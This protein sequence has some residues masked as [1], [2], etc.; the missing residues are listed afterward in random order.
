MG[1]TSISVDSVPSKA[2]TPQDHL[3]ELLRICLEKD[4]SPF[5]SEDCE[6]P[7]LVTWLVKERS[8]FSK[9]AN[10][11]IIVENELKAKLWSKYLQ[12]LTLFNPR[13]L[14]N[15]EEIKLDSYEKLLISTPEGLKSD[16]IRK[17]PLCLL[18]IDNGHQLLLNET[19]RYFSNSSNLPKGRII[20]LAS[21][22]LRDQTHDK[23]LQPN[24]LK[25]IVESRFNDFLPNPESCSDLLS[26][27]RFFCNPTQQIIEYGVEDQEKAKDKFKDTKEQINEIVA[28]CYSFFRSHHYSLLE[29]YGEEYKD[30]IDDVPDPTELP[31]KLLDDFVHIKNTLGLWCAERAALLLIIKIDRLKTREKYERHFLLLSVLYTEMVKVR[32]ICESVFNEMSDHERLMNFST[33]QLLKLVEILRQYKP[34]HVCRAK[35]STKP[36]AASTGMIEFYAKIQSKYNSAIVG[37]LRDSNT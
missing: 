6:K 18:I 34:E 31:L 14:E 20:I 10:I 12:S 22:L 27:L 17:K 37:F 30:D 9:D 7:F 29:I 28:N 4:C 32:K 8:K 19:V 25:S 5:L 16:F 33:P 21:S 36:T 24:A 11:L 1:I 3:V 2:F 15:R 26:M 13:I 23:L 35:Q